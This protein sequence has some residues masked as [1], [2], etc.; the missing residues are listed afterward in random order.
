VQRLEGALMQWTRRVREV[1]ARQDAD[2]AGA[3]EGPLGELAFWRARSTDLSGIRDQLDGRGARSAA[4]R[5]CVNPNPESS[6]AMA[7]MCVSA[8]RCRLLPTA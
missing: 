5:I 7:C 4:C 8:E 3:A 1:A 2:G 6:E